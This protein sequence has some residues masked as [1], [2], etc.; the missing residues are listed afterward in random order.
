M[1]TTTRSLEEP[2]SIA[3]AAVSSVE[4]SSITKTV[5]TSDWRRADRTAR[6]IVSAL[7]QAAITTSTEPAPSTIAAMVRLYSRIARRFDACIAFVTSF[8]A[9]ESLHID[10]VQHDAEEI[11]VNVARPAERVLDDFDAGAS[12]FDDQDESIDKSSRDAGVDDRSEGR[13]ID[14]DVIVRLAQLVKK[15]SR[16][17][18]A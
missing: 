17:L 13:E 8:V 9:R 11:G 14:D 4:Q 1:R 5:R 3:R 16:L 6:S 15:L 7:F 2:A 18:A 10:L 12:P